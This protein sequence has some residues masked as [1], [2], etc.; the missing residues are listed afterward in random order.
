MTQSCRATPPFGFDEQVCR[1][2]EENYNSIPA[3]VA[4]FLDIPYV[5]QNVAHTE[6]SRQLME[7]MVA[8]FTTKDAG[9]TIVGDNRFDI[10][11][12]ALEYN[13]F[14]LIQHSV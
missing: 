3:F 12:R 10:F 5:A 4:A 7:K 8:D 1:L 13:I 6:K 11:Y 14:C 2:W 9:W